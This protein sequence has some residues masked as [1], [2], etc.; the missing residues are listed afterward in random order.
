MESTSTNRTAWLIVAIVLVLAC[1]CACLAAMAG[2]GWALF[3]QPARQ[4]IGASDLGQQPIVRSFEVGAEP[5]LEVNAHAGTIVIRPGEEGVI[6]VVATRKARRD[7]TLAAIGIEMHERAN[8]LAVRTTAP[9]GRDKGNTA[10]DL[11][12]SAPPGTRLELHAA[13]GNVDVRGMVGDIRARVDLGNIDVHAAEGVAHLDVGAG[14]VQYRGRPAGACTFEAGAGNVMVELAADT[15]A[16]VD[17]MT[18]VGEVDV[19]PQVKGLVTPRHVK[20]TIGSGDQA[21]IRARC[22]VGNVSLARR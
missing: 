13:V 14:N 3:A 17:L 18:G 21:D 12:I 20:G 15:D 11:E 6:K 7:P 1:G 2:A 19:G 16:R 9:R 22:G 4:S 5:V 8:G 10:V